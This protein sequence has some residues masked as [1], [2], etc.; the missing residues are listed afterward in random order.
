[1]DLK[2]PVPMF[3]VGLLVLTNAAEGTWSERFND[4]LNKLA[5]EALGVEKMQVIL[6]SIVKIG[7]FYPFLFI[8]T[9]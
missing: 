9:Y 2:H 8:G 1:M 6:N 5:N 4:L 3:M 7:V